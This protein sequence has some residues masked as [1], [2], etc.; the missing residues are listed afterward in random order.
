MEISEELVK[1][2]FY[3]IFAAIVSFLLFSGFVIAPRFMTIL[4][5]FW[6]LFI[7]T[8]LFFFFIIFFGRFCP[9]EKEASSENTGEGLLDYV[10]EQPE[11][12]GEGHQNS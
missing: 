11:H 7:S 10:A 4:A 12:V 6:P 9:L 8:F 1:Y 3:I 5:Y 2:K